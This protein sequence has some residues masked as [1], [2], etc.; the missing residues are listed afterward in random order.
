MKAKF[1]K[2]IPPELSRWLNACFN[3]AVKRL[4]VA[5]YDRTVCV[6]VGYSPIGDPRTE[7]G[8]IAPMD[9]ASWRWPDPPR[10]FM[11]M[12]A[13]DNPPQMLESLCHELIHL[14]QWCRGE[15]SIGPKDKF[16]YH[17]P[18]YFN[19][20]IRGLPYEQRPFEQEAHKEMT[21]LAL[22]VVKQVGW[23]DVRK[24]VEET[25]QMLEQRRAA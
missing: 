15:L 6:R 3:V 25:K 7:R 16:G 18:L 20:N 19:Q 4:G 12:L 21:Q 10:A 23:P 17:Q 11:L 9:H 14:G 22:D 24:M 2:T 1:S 13:P 8:A 5:D